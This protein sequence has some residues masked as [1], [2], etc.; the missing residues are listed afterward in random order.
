MVGQ[1]KSDNIFVSGEK[2]KELMTTGSSGLLFL[3]QWKNKNVGLF[4]M[5][6]LIFDIQIKIPSDLFYPLYP[7][8]CP[9]KGIDKKL[10]VGAAHDFD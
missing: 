5:G 4:V 9:K 7:M 8:G 1:S 6:S 3:L 2:A 10:L